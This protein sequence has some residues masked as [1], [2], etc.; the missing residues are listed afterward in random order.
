MSKLHPRRERIDDCAFVE[1]DTALV[2]DPTVEPVQPR[3]L[4]FH[5]WPK[6]GAHQP[7]IGLFQQL[8]RYLHRTGGAN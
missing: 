5:H 7:E 3:A 1:G 6:G 8:I 2:E 4:T